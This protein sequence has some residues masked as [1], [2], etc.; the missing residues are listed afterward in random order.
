[1]NPRAQLLKRLDNAWLAFKKSYAGLSDA[2]VLEPGVTGAWSV[3]D[4]IAH[5]TTWEEEALKHLPLILK[6]GKP[7][8]YSVTYG[9]INAFNAHTTKERRSFCSPTCFSRAMPFINASS[10]LSRMRRRMSSVAGH[11]SGAV[12]VL[13]PTATTRSMRRRYAGGGIGGVPFA[14]LGAMVDV[15]QRLCNSCKKFLPMYL[16]IIAVNTLMALQAARATA[17]NDSIPVAFA[18]PPR[19]APRAFPR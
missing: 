17:G 7:P 14:T 13:T 4:I 1:M 6:G 16:K 11:A 15:L 12:F 3:R 9:G 18:P 10:H 5:V 2:E 19:P 8:R